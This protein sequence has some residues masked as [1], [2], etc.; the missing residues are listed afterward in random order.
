L[1]GLIESDKS[2]ATVVQYRNQLR[3][4]YN[5][6][7]I[8]NPANTPDV[9][10]IIKSLKTDQVEITGESYQQTQATPLRKAHLDLLLDRHDELDQRLT[11][12]L[13]IT[14]RKAITIAS[15]LY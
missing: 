2:I 8:F 4:F 7:L 9:S 3:Y 13:T 15:T 5:Y 12:Q 10:T 1:M 11:Y 14:E 6:L